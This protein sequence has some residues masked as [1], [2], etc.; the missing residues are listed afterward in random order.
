M[1]HLMRQAPRV[2]WDRLIF[3]MKEAVY[4]A[5]FPLTGDPLDFEDALILPRPVTSASGSFET[6][7]LVSGRSAR[8]PTPNALSGRWL[9]RDGIILTAVTLPASTAP[10]GVRPLQET[11]GRSM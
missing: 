4:K 2:S 8:S 6:H 1:R 11:G 7:L 5:W 3:S 9:V 10:L